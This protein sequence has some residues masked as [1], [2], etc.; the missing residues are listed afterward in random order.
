MS[1]ARKRTKTD[2]FRQGDASDN[3]RTQSGGGSASVTTD[4]WLGS[5]AVPLAAAAITLATLVAY[6][7]SFGNPFLFDDDP[8]ILKN[9]TIRRLWAI[10]DVLC[11]PKNGETVTGRP[12]LNLTMAINYAISGEEPWSYH[13]G[14]LAIH[15]LAALTLFSI[16][17]RTF[18]LPTMC[19]RWGE[20][21]LPLAF[22]IALL[23]AIH[24]MQTESVTYVVQRAESL[25][26]LLYLLTLY[27][28]LRSVCSPRPMAWWAATALVCLLGMASKE[29]M[30]SAPLV[31][32]L[33]DR[34]FVATSWREV[35]RRRW[36][37][38]AAMA[39]TWTLLAW[40][41]LTTGDRGGSAGFGVSMSRRA[42]LGTQ[43]GAILHYL[44]LAVWPHPLVFDYGTP[45]VQ[46]LKEV[47][48]SGAAVLLLG[49]ATLAALW[50]WPKVGFLG[51]WFFAILAP[52]SSVVPVVTQT[53]AEH[54]MYL[55]LAAVWTGIVAACCWAGRQMVQARRISL[56]GAKMAAVAAVTVVAIL[57][58]SMTHQRNLVYRSAFAMWEDTLAK[59]PDSAR[60]HNN[61][62]IQLVHAGRVSEGMA[63][64]R[65]AVELK[66]DF[67]DPHYNL[68]LEFGDQ[69]RTEEAMA[70]YE[71][72]LKIKPDHEGAMN[73]LAILLVDRGR[74]DEAIELYKKVIEIKPS[75]GE[76]RYNYANALVAQKKYK[77]AIP[78]YE[79][80]VKLKP[81]LADAHCDL[82]LL[83]ATCP[84]PT[85]R[86]GAKAVACARRAAELTEW[87]DPSILETLAAAYAEAG[88][89][90]EAVQYARLALQFAT[91]QRRLDLAKT[92]RSRLKL[93]EAG[94]PYHESETT[95]LAK[96]Q[97]A[98][99]TPTK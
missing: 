84:D 60:A 27:C 18:L 52:T 76:V 75:L 20:N 66:P 93:Y 30:A 3:S 64:Y 98:A 19:R 90:S 37:L 70:E 87:K 71:A 69:G 80:A 85:V 29:V 10:S 95:P 24:P 25:V 72:A 73:S 74:I 12:L 91:G 38:Y 41:V 4:S 96:P 50:R 17:R 46:S 43:T 7:N 65:K 9:P 88:N 83:L 89:F 21:A 55:P 26:G 8:T 5:W 97:G 56:Q 82:A 39:C 6:E 32:C 14:N 44:R 47:V 57:F 81:D 92:I 58:V 79:A 62:G 22:V 40:L 68:G 51:A 36:A 54:R 15:I 16:L 31:V 63:E 48:P 28:F 78:L 2:L 61:F 99:R 35:F 11:P 86:D 53:I 33:F 49:L 59:M 42:Y 67:V 13:A 23:W 45:L 34:A 77:E 1:M 94:T